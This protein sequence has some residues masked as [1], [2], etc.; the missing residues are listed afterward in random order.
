MDRDQRF[1]RLRAGAAFLAGLTIPLST[2]ASDIITVLAM[3]LVLVERP[4]RDAWLRVARNPVVWA[5]LALFVMLG[6]GVTYSVASWH[7]ASVF[8][9]KYRKLAYLPLLLL[10]CRD[11]QAS[12]A[13]LMGMLASVAI[14]VIAGIFLWARS[15]L[16]PGAPVMGYSY[17]GSYIIEGVWIAEAAYFMAIEAIVSPRWRKLWIAGIVLALVFLLYISIGRTGYVVA[18]MLAF[19]L[20]FQAAPRRWLLPG[21][22]GIVLIAASVFYL[23]PELASRMNSVVSAAEGTTNGG[24]LS[25]RQRIM[26]YQVSLQAIGQHPIFG[27]GTG[28]FAQVFNPLL[29]SDASYAI[30]TNPHNEYLIIGVQIGV[31]GVGLLLA[32]IAAL[33]FLAAR[34]PPPDSW[35]A[36]CVTVALAASCLFN[37]S[38]LDHANGHSFMLQ[39]ALFYFGVVSVGGGGRE[40]QRHRH[41]I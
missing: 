36:R 2:T 8:W 10:L 9:L 11:R 7:D 34:L 20:L 26:F 6:I 17:F 38:L 14:I 28:S 21:I 18:F 31:V 15:Q 5:S 39:I 1:A 25:A 23:A 24:T 13:G 37:S 32:M 35:R 3:V 16:Q 19:L 40:D 4:P 33:W 22:A 12:R 27:T 29:P 30:T 41:D